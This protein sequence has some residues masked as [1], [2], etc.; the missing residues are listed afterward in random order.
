METGDKGER[1]RQKKLMKNQKPSKRKRGAAVVSTALLGESFKTSIKDS[2]HAA[3]GEVWSEVTAQ[4]KGNVHATL[5]GY[6][7]CELRVVDGCSGKEW[8]TS[9]LSD[10][11]T[12]YL[13]D[14]DGN[15]GPEESD[16]CDAIAADMEKQ[17]KRLRKHSAQLCLSNAKSLAQPPT[18]MPE[19]KGDN[20]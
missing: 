14:R 2:L 19:R 11:V 1:G 8:W 7:R 17:A 16:W 18:A 3:F 6:D 13:S 15:C 10:L 9:K 20:Q 4:L 12:E 5:D